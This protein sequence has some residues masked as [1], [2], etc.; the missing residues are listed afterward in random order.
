MLLPKQQPIEHGVRRRSFIFQRPDRSRSSAERASW[1]R[2]PEPA[3]RRECYLFPLYLSFS[4]FWFQTM[5]ARY[6]NPS[7]GHPS[8]SLSILDLFV[9]NRSD[10][11]NAQRNSFTGGNNSM[12][13]ADAIATLVR[14]SQ[15]QQRSIR[16]KFKTRGLTCNIR[17]LKNAH[18]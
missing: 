3:Q 15:I 10:F 16:N 9:P 1:R 11:R 14:V 18:S 17:F 13:S 6:R 12:L 5:R 7:R 8:V 2:T 4:S